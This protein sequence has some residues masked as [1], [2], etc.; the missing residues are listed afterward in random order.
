MLRNI[1]K[2]FNVSLVMVLPLFWKITDDIRWKREKKIKYPF[3]QLAFEYGLLNT[4]LY[5]DSKFT[6]NLYLLFDRE[7]FNRSMTVT[8][9]KYYSLCELLVDCEYFNG[10][11][12]HNDYI[13]VLLRIPDK[14]HN[15]INTIMRGKYSE[16]SSEY[17]DELYFKKKFS[18][19]PK[20]DNET[21]VYIITN[22]LAYAI[23]I[24]AQHLRDQLEDI[25]GAIS[26]TTESEFYIA[27]DADKENLSIKTLTSSRELVKA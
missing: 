26:D 23:S 7:I 5:R 25:I 8:D 6:G 9:S 12:V 21:G 24:K 11:E 14:F 2:N 27:P 15:E 10:L 13:V 3:M 4:F 18:F 1:W 22:D 16:L 17:K 19:I 20:S